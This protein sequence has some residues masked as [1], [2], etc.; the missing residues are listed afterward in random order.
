MDAKRF[1]V[2]VNI[3]KVQ[4]DLKKVAKLMKGIVECYRVVI[5]NMEQDRV[6]VSGGKSVLHEFE[7]ISDYINDAAERHTKCLKEIGL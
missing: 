6:D 4:K 1:E 7:E 3:V 2:Y 5:G